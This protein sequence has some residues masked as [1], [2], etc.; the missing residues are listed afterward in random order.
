MVNVTNLKNSSRCYGPFKFA[1]CFL[2]VTVV[3]LL[4]VMSYLCSMFYTNTKSIYLVNDQMFLL[5]LHTLLTC[6]N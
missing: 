6:S 4:Q 2:H 1:L 5:A 3:M